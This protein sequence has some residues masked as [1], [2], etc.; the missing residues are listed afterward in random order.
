MCV[1]VRGNACVLKVSILSLFLRFLVWILELCVV[2]VLYYEKEIRSMKVH[3]CKVWSPPVFLW[4]WCLVGVYATF[5]NISV[6]SWR[7]VCF[8]WMKPEDPENTTDKFY[9]IL[10]YRVHL[11]MN[12][13]ECKILVVIGTDCIGSCKSNYHTITATTAPCGS[14][15][16]PFE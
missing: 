11:A 16:Y 8:W 2:F 5:N 10:F 1:K 6:I 15:F 9:H 3:N 7:S 12:G 4:K 14:E 13:F